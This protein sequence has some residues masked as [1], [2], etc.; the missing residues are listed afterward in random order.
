MGSM[1]TTPRVKRMYARAIFLIGRTNLS[2]DPVE[3]VFIFI[4]AG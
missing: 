2:Q 4:M 1:E 3:G